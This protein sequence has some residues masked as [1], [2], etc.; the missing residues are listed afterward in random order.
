[1]ASAAYYIGAYANYILADNSISSAF[2]SIGVYIS[3]L[4]NK[5]KMQKEGVKLRTI[6][7]PQSTLKNHEYREL[8][9]NDNEA[10]LIED[11]LTPSADRFI[12]SVKGN[13]K[14]RIKEDSDAYKGKLFEGQ[15]IIDEGLADG[16]GTLYDAISIAAGLA[17]W[18]TK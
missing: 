13:R 1:V 2:G 4:D 9:E 8:T 15:A 7:A 10:P 16:F 17:M 18:K 11:V 3:F 5:E 14:G 12:A 6:Y